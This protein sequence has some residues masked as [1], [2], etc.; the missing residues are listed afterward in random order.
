MAANRSR[1][2][3]P[4]N[5]LQLPRSELYATHRTF[6]SAHT[7]LWSVGTIRSAIDGHDRG[8]FS[9]SAALSHALMR[10]CRVLSAVT[11]R[12][13]TVLGL[14]LE[15]EPASRAWEGKPLA[16]AIRE[17]ALELFTDTA[18][19]LSPQTQGWFL[20]TARCF[21]GVAIAQIVWETSED[22]WT[23][24]V[25]PWPMEHSRWNEVDQCYEV[26]THDAGYLQIQPGDG[27]W[28]VYTPFGSRS[29]MGGPIRALGMAW[30]DR[31]YAIRD[32]S[33]RSEMAGLSTFIGTLPEGIRA[34]TNDA[35][36]FKTIL[37]S[38]QSGRG[39][40][41]KPFGYEVEPIQIDSNGYEI[42]DSMIGGS[43]EDI[44]LAILGQ[45]A[46]STTKAGLGQGGNETH[47]GVRMDL[48]EADVLSFF[49]GCV[50]P[51]IVVPW[52]ALNW[53]RVELAPKPTR[54]VPD[55]EEDDR[56]AAKAA[57][58]QA[59]VA[60]VTGLRS[61]GV[62]PD[63]ERLAEE[64]GIR[65]PAAELSTPE[66]PEPAEPEPMVEPNDDEEATS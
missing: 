63:L 37:Q 40:M 19:A 66:A 29:W 33:R 52:V 31:T 5:V 44:Q 24:R 18:T 50:V 22:R 47:D 21:L 61:V 32:R 48:T 51:Q 28:I 8:D 35:A 12:V 3:K 57:R 30:A 60:T 16:E 64:H 45:T 4:G 38:L 42:F 59:F 56:L 55:V 14:P 7:N 17:E 43:N 62:N 13:E 54:K 65:I 15:I 34:N 1:S 10:D 26:L 41:V 25:V 39:G 58:Y 2:Q 6:S 53:G 49:A 46:T 11:Q 20:R 9:Q 36:G 23:P 27:K